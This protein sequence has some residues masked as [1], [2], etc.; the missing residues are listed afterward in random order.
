MKVIRQCNWQSVQHY[1]DGGDKIKTMMEA[2]HGQ[3]CELSL[4][5]GKQSNDNG[6]LQY[7]KCHYVV[8]TVFYTT[9]MANALEETVFNSSSFNVLRCAKITQI[10]HIPSCSLLHMKAANQFKW[11]SLECIDYNDYCSQHR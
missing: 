4:F 2:I 5:G 10:F 3:C 1:D 9:Y 11:K 7:P 6:G 8:P